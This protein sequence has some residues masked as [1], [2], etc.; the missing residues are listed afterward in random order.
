MKFR[1]FLLTL[2]LAGCSADPPFRPGD[3][4]VSAKNGTELGKVIELGDHSFENGAA[5]PS[6]HVEL[7]S[8]KNRWF[9]LD[10]TVGTYVVKH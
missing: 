3:V 6:V 5:G 1:V 4:L 7:P 8:G 10:T 2:L 9:T